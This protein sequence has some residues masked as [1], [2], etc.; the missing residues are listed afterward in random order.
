MLEHIIW[1][2]DRA[3]GGG[4]GKPGEGPGRWI[5]PKIFDSADEDR[6]KIIEKL[7][8]KVQAAKM[9][10][11]AQGKSDFMSPLVA[12]IVGTSAGLVT[13]GM[14]ANLIGAGPD[15]HLWIKAHPL[16]R[17]LLG[18][19]PGL[20]ATLS[21][22]V[23]G[24]AALY[25]I[26]GNR[27]KKV[28]SKKLTAKWD[29]IKPENHELIHIFKAGATDP[30]YS[31]DDLFWTNQHWL[32]D[33]AKEFVK[34]KDGLKPLDW[35][36]Y[37]RDGEFQLYVG[38]TYEPM[39]RFNNRPRLLRVPRTG[40]W[41]GVAVFGPT[42]K[43]KS[44]SIA[45][46]F[47]DQALGYYHW[48]DS[49]RDIW[50][51]GAASQAMRLREQAEKVRGSE[52]SDLLAKADSISKEVQR[53][54]S[55]MAE[56]ND[57][58]IG[59][60]KPGVI[61]IEP[62]DEIHATQY[63]LCKRFGRERDYIELGVVQ[64]KYGKYQ[65]YT[66]HL[67]ESCKQLWSYISNRGITDATLKWLLG[68]AYK[69]GI[70]SSEKA[71]DF[72]VSVE[73]RD[74]KV[75]LQA[76]NIKNP[77]AVFPILNG[78]YGDSSADSRW[79]EV[80]F[81]SANAVRRDGARFASSLRQDDRSDVRDDYFGVLLDQALANP[82]PLSGPPKVQAP[83]EIGVIPF[84]FGTMNDPW[85]RSSA[86][87]SDRGVRMQAQQSLGQRLVVEPFQRMIYFASLL[88][89]G[90]RF[91]DVR[92]GDG[93][94]RLRPTTSVGSVVQWADWSL[95][96][97]ETMRDSQDLLT[98]LAPD[99]K[100][101]DER[102]VAD[103][104]L[105]V[106]IVNPTAL[107][108]P[109]ISKTRLSSAD[110]QDGQL[111]PAVEEPVA[112]QALKEALNL[113]PAEKEENKLL[114]KRVRA[115]APPMMRPGELRYD[116]RKRYALWMAERRRKQF[117]FVDGLLK[118][119]YTPSPALSVVEDG[120][121]SQGGAGVST[122]LV[123]L[124]FRACPSGMAEAVLRYALNADGSRE[125]VIAH[126]R[127]LGYLF[128]EGTEEESSAGSTHLE[129][130]EVS[131]SYDRAVFK[132]LRP[133]PDL[134]ARI[135]S[136]RGIS[137][138]SSTGRFR[139]RDSHLAFRRAEDSFRQ[140]AVLSALC[141]R[142]GLPEDLSALV[143]TLRRVL[144]EVSSEKPGAD[145]V[146][147]EWAAAALSALRAR[148]AEQKLIYDY[149]P[150]VPTLD[151]I[152]EDPEDFEAVVDCA[153]IGIPLGPWDALWCEGVGERL[154][155]GFQEV[156]R[157]VMTKAIGLYA[158][159]EAR[160]AREVMP[161]G[162][163]LGNQR[164]TVE[165]ALKSRRDEVF[166]GAMTYL[167][168][169]ERYLSS[170]A[171]YYKVNT[172]FPYGYRDF[173]GIGDCQGP[174]KFNPLHHPDMTPKQV[175]SMLL[176][177]ISRR[178]GSGDTSFWNDSGEMITEGFLSLLRAGLGYTTVE[179][180]NQMIVSDAFADLVVAQGEARLRRMRDSAGGA[181]SGEVIRQKM[182]FDQWAKLYGLEDDPARMHEALDNGELPAE[183]E[184]LLPR[185]A[186]GTEIKNLE[187][188]LQAGRSFMISEWR[189][190]RGSFSDV[191]LRGTCK[192]NLINQLTALTTGIGA[193]SFSPEDEEELSFP[194]PFETRNRGLCVATRFNYATNKALGGI[195][196]G[197][198]IAAY[199]GMVLSAKQRQTQAKES[200]VRIQDLISD[201]R[202]KLVE[203]RAETRDLRK[204]MAHPKADAASVQAFLHAQ[205]Q[206]LSQGLDP[207][208]AADHLVSALLKAEGEG[209]LQ[210]RQGRPGAKLA[211]ESL[212]GA[213]FMASPGGMAA[214][215]MGQVGGSATRVQEEVR[216]LLDREVNL[217]QER[218]YETADRVNR[219]EALIWQY[220]QEVLNAL[221][222]M[223]EFAN[224]SRIMLFLIDEYQFFAN[225][226]TKGS[227]LTDVDFLSTSR[228][229]K[230]INVFITQTPSSVKSS[231]MSMDAWEQ[232]ISNTL[233]RICLGAPN[234]SDQEYFSDL[235]RGEK[236]KK[237]KESSFNLSFEG[238][239]IS[240]ASGD[241]RASEVGSGSKSFTITEEYEKFVTPD[242][243]AEM[244]TFTSYVQMTD[245]QR[246]FRPQ[247]VYQPP[248]FLTSSK[249]MSTVTGE[250]IAQKTFLALVRDGELNLNA[251]D[252]DNARAMLEDLAR[253]GGEVDFGEVNAIES[254]LK[255]AS[256]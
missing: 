215:F 194:T 109:T 197:M 16:F 160:L 220:R 111:S 11:Q 127:T 107:V 212:G 135:C 1:I 154:W 200:F 82:G 172:A 27:E 67:Q 213:A 116:F 152:T 4:K 65:T 97:H 240:K 255:G 253:L 42:G 114:R 20:F 150:E 30:R 69:N 186:S 181:H 125:P 49:E 34:T 72:W 155:P 2:P 39:G 6:V 133:S 185:S 77:S 142:V 80:A 86:G 236:V 243:L 87:L 92:R 48:V 141:S 227:V 8:R 66:A 108:T 18:H 182:V 83:R 254:R 25:E 165:G 131:R 106:P 144:G 229:G 5:N 180:L 96:V 94:S 251:P 148:D 143:Q 214:R 205:Y 93:S 59:Y 167:Q 235:F 55:D 76:R 118:V 26:A 88:G 158:E 129:T 157:G 249:N 36:R 239:D 28:Q 126:L 14:L 238:V 233:L 53:R 15:S 242:D 244:R 35:G 207:A 173:G 90:V 178:A 23:G 33:S 196:L 89:G 184:A 153:P 199:Q 46:P 151:P 74:Y 57:P 163:A 241:L 29:R 202:K 99:G 246:S 13:S 179:A 164:Y 24:F 17:P 201:R 52:R 61:V 209:R 136:A 198:F 56:G 101:F 189:S 252:P 119:L 221:S 31:A 192:L 230:S 193:F 100:A 204:E 115:S 137:Y 146:S 104:N 203:L 124:L 176:G 174:T 51:F 217:R 43:G 183:L 145:G 21:L 54:L 78:V 44:A 128:F 45:L 250:P 130:A 170:L 177:I 190:D 79:V 103:L 122:P 102:G 228:A 58:A 113:L 117:D 38:E 9:Y 62:K 149:N 68:F 132:G 95:G 50:L 63:E 161:D 10:E 210:D 225:T 32:P 12:A 219:N 175:A 71:V 245:G 168:C 81:G 147:V 40:L 256:S 248:Y 138:D 231:G 169:F 22:E 247:L 105:P 222:E 120:L 218:E 206:A 75:P 134:I 156:S 60:E 195:V 121:L 70:L 232:W 84:G 91:G 123:G 112:I 139:D 162:T 47:I 73:R 224:W 234:K 208:T 216:R 140:A 19:Y 85:M 159:E 171:P 37:I 64:E 166:A 188:N 237:E 98:E 226:N 187:A 191:E 211:Y 7:Y 3:A 110:V 41:T 223:E